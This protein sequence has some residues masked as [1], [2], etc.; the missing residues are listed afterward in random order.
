MPSFLVLRYHVMDVLNEKKS[1][2]I[3]LADRLELGYLQEQK[4]LL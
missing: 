1:G 4:S 3:Q 2:A